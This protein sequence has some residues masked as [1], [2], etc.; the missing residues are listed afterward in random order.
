MLHRRNRAN[1]IIFLVLS[2]LLLTAIALYLASQARYHLP[3]GLPVPL[4]LVSVPLPLFAIALGVWALVFTLNSV[5]DGRRTARAVD[6]IQWVVLA[7]AIAS[8]AFAGVLYILYRELPR[9]IFIY[10]VMFDTT[11]LLGYRLLLR[12][13]RRFAVSH[14]R[15]TERILIIG[16]G[17]VG[18]QVGKRV[19]EEHWSGVSLVGYL[20]DNPA[21]KDHTFEGAPVLGSLA[22][23]AAIVRQYQV[24]EIIIALPLRAHKLMEEVVIALHE[25]P[26]NVRVVP[27]FF[28]LV[29]FRATI[30]DLGGIPLIGL[31]DP[32]IDGYRRVIKRL[33]D[34]VIAVPVMIFLA[35]LM[36]AI[37][38]AVKLDSPG[39]V[40]F[41]QQRVGENGRPFWMYKFR[42][43]VVDAEQHQEEVI[44]ETPNGIVL[45]KRPDDPRIT[46]LGRILRRT[47]LDELPQLTNVL[48]GEMSL[49]GP[50]P[51]LPYL[52]QRYERWQRQR[53][54][55]P[56]GITGWW[57]I[58]GRSERP[59][60]LHTEDDLYYIQNYSPLLDLQI[61]WRTVGVVLRGRGAY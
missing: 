60:H 56:P 3:Y 2:D 35:P 13:A 29:F 10:F 25:L 6:E 43:M 53:F 51:E 50:R 39:P 5:Y 44:E 11:F 8:F 26:V 57:Q 19:Q 55:V 40:I 30:E 32:A 15:E 20:D 61:L 9:R 7:I 41:R 21:K 42:S 54:A 27:D 49:V 46:R 31:R 1:I 14:R 33:F 59:M 12:M 16:A 52:V 38:V 34:L 17:K 47:S 45:N 23:A 28:D 24:D 58:S 48:K 22:D 4:E 37:T 36:A 18:R